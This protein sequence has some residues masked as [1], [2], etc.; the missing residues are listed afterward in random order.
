MTWLGVVLHYQDRTEALP[1]IDE[2]A[3]L[4]Y[5]LASTLR[6]LQVGD[7]TKVV[8]IA[9]GQGEPDLAAALGEPRH[10]LHRVAAALGETY[11]LRA[12][13]IAAGRPVPDD[14]D[15]V[16]LMGSRSPLGPAA[17]YSLDQ[18]VMGGGALGIF[19]Y[20]A[21]PDTQTLRIAPAPF[22]ASE[23]TAAWGVRVGRS[24]LAE[25]EMNDAIRLP[26][27]IETGRGVIQGQKQ[28]SSPLV[29]ILRDLDSSHPI[30]RRLDTLVAPFATTIDSSE[31]AALPEV[32]ATVLAR[33][34]EQSRAGLTFASLDPGANYALLQQAESGAG[35]APSARPGPHA[36]LVAVHGPL[37]SAWA[38]SPPPTAT[39]LPTIERAPSG[40]RAVIGSSFELPLANP[41]L[42]LSIVDWLAADE[43]LLGIRPR[44][45][46]PPLLE[47]P[48]QLRLVRLA[49][50]AGVPGLVAL[51]G[52]LRLRRRRLRR[53]PTS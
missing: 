31:A 8:G 36:A 48:E 41:G 21:L 38:G 52:F 20:G 2:T 40:T 26:V 27:R 25:P 5:Q 29:P 22:D 35:G 12:V 43:V 17:R 9:T 15:V 19:P 42:L 45:S 10:P 6:T 13:D 49:N 34:S 4:E 53:A 37:P 39:D 7:A 14:V 24:L 23:L 32:T 50:V 30:T 16:I 51:I 18:F 47:I 44:L 46:T 28:V 11:S 1:F 3:T 33:S